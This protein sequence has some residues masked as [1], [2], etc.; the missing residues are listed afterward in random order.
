MLKV[1]GLKDKTL[2]DAAYLYLPSD[3]TFS[4]SFKTVT[5]RQLLGHVSGLRDEGGVCNIDLATLKTC[6][7]KPLKA[8]DWA[9]A[10]TN[11]ALVRVMLSKL[12][13]LNATSAEDYGKNYVNIVN[14]QIFNRARLP[15][16]TCKS[17]QPKPALSYK[18]DKD[19]GSITGFFAPNYDWTT[20]LPG[21][22]WGDMTSVCG[23]Q[24]WNLSS[25]ELAIFMRA[26]M[27]SEKL[28]PQ[29]RVDEMRAG[30]LGLF[31]SDFGDGLEAY[32]HG[33]WHPA[34]SNK[35]EVNTVIFTYSN[36]VTLGMIINSRY[37]GD[38]GADLA[39]AVKSG[40]I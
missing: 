30:G 9:Y 39:K 18:S 19:D 17:P 23:S 29:T 37:N 12:Y 32:G 6:V 3:W 27:L 4:T 13:G 40:G 25:R 5:I 24:G 20:V 10:N 2:D 14:R 31:W 26:L 15:F 11:Y 21:Q 34:G 28:L 22:D 16:E 36:G 7:S 8:K 1:L 38:L 33:G 35:G